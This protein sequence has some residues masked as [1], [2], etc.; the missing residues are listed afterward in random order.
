MTS[1]QGS[2]TMIWLKIAI[3]IPYLFIFFPF[4]SAGDVGFE[5][6]DG[7]GMDFKVVAEEPVN[8]RAVVGSNVQ[9]GSIKAGNG[10]SESGGKFIGGFEQVYFSLSDYRE[11]VIEPLGKPMAY[12]HDDSRAAQP[13]NPSF[14]D[15]QRIDENE[16]M[17]WLLIFF[18][19]A[20]SSFVSS[21]IIIFKTQQKA[22][23]ARYT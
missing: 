11:R 23:G 13:Q 16:Q 8:F 6:Y 20:I 9:D 14:W 18:I 22:T 17:F 3:F 2:A 19:A 21:M 7:S 1:E 15:A 5:L 12:P 4:A 10:G